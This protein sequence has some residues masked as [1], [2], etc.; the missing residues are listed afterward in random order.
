MIPY[1]DVIGKYTLVPTWIVEPNQSW[2]ELAYYDLGE[3]EIYAPATANNLEALKAGNYVKIPNKPYLWIIKSVQYLY[4]SNGSRIISAKGFEAK[5]IISTR[6][7][8]NPSVIS[9]NLETSVKQLIVDNIINPSVAA[10][11]IDNVIWNDTTIN[12]TIDDTQAARG[13]LWE[14][15]YG[16][17]KANNCGLYSTF[18]NNKIVLQLVN[19]LDR[20]NEII[21]SQQFDNLY[22]STYTVN[23]SNLRTYCQVVSTFSEERDNEKYDVEYIQSYDEGTTGIDRQEMTIDSNLST[24]LDDGTEIAPDSATYQSWQQQE[25]KNKLAENIIQ[26]DFTGE[27]DLQHS[28][29]K[30]ETDYFIG[31]QIR[32][33]DEYFNVVAKARILK[34]SFAQDPQKYIET[35][36]YQTE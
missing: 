11:K 18:E 20:S 5:W 1:I 15:L 27:I 22:S 26:K 2:F 19:G 23:S 12:I 7:I 31:D 4:T 14:F 8:L 36:D 32:I 25:G 28:Q 6:A 33:V 13:N 16:L 30:F 17:L 35:A 24:K 9:S 29:W 34:Y 21:F 10:R 3:F